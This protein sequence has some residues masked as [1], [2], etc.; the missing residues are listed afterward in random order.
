MRYTPNRRFDRRRF[1]VTADRTKVINVYPVLM[2]GGIR[3]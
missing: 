3:L 2:R 1:E